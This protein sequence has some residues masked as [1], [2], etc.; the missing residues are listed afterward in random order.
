M[1][2]MQHVKAYMMHYCKVAANLGELV[3]WDVYVCFSCTPFVYGTLQS[4]A[5]IEVKPR[6]P[7]AGHF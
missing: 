4:C 2:D 3:T 5:S 6:G 7:R 1:F